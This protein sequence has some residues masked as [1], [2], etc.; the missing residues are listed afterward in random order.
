MCRGARKFVRLSEPHKS[1]FFDDRLDIG[2]VHCKFPEHEQSEV[3]HEVTAK[4]AA[5]NCK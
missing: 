3:H 2:G 1:A 5:K 4:L